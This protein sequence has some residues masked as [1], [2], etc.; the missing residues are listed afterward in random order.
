[1]NVPLARLDGE[2]LA[3]RRVKPKAKSPERRKEPRIS[4]RYEAIIESSKGQ[5]EEVLLIDVS[6]HGCCVETEAD[7]LRNGSFVSIGLDDQP[8]LSAIVRWVR[9]GSV[10][11]EFLRPIP[12]DRDE[13]HEML[14]MPF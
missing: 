2:K 11:M 12:T 9:D 1:M 3:Q 10:G 13:W 6:M 7:W 5:S 14:D 4:A 8:K